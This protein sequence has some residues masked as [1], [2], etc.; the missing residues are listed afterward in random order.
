MSMDGITSQA[1]SNYYG[2]ESP[3]QERSAADHTLGPLT[4]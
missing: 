4:F 1:I 2:Q 3:E